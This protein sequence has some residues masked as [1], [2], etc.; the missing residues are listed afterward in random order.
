[1]ARFHLVLAMIMF[2]SSMD[3]GKRLIAAGR[4][5]EEDRP[6]NFGFPE[7]SP[8]F[9]RIPIWP[10]ETDLPDHGDRPPNFGF[11]ELSPPF[12]EIPIWPPETHSLA[13]LKTESRSSLPPVSESV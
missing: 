1:M 6:P 13:D 3:A 5:L 10:P 2:I 8:P 12:P 4:H 7:L 11:P 9:P